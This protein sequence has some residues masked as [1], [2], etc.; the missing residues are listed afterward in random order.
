MRNKA[1]E[2]IFR[3]RFAFFLL[4]IALFSAG[5]ATA[6]RAQEE[7]LSPKDRIK[8]FERV[9]DLIND[10]YY[11]PNM[12]GVNWKAEREK[13]RPLVETA[14]NDGEFY[15]VLKRLTGELKDAHTRFLTPREA[16]E[17]R[18][19]QATTAGVLISKVE[20]RSVVERVLPE[21]DAA[22]AGIKAGM[23][24]RTIDGRPVAEKLA[25]IAK[26]LGPSSSERA[27]EI[28]LYRRLLSGEP[29]TRLKLGLRNEKGKDFEVELT[30]T[31]VSQESKVSAEKLPSGVGYIIVS[32]FKAPVSDK[33]KDA[34]ID[35]QDAPGLIIDLRY[36]GGGNIS[37]VLRMA[38]FFLNENRSFGK[39]L[40]RDGEEHQFLKDFT[41]GE[42]GGQIYAGPVVILVSQ[43]SASGS[44]L[45]SSGLQE[46]GRAQV[47]G[48]QTCGCLLGISRFHRMKGGGE[49]H[50]SD[51]G[52]LSAKGKIY[53]KVGVTP[54]RVVGLKIDDL[55]KDFDR[56]VAEAETVI[57]A[58]A[59]MK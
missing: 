25:E 20:G 46:F 33:F 6:V 24:V 38:G 12:N 45:F 19:R 3:R 40:R 50:I 58:S 22:R 37:E 59:E 17:F 29:G 14:R 39:F 18:T 54:D 41:A 43:Y 10:R 47:I 35:L 48:T 2:E 5:S 57:S 56:G 36:N 9:W 31:V 52:F 49:L 55:R 34:L 15:D 27:T 23:L 1:V 13:Y 30:R 11:D 32:S 53:E 16:R 28:L 8:V 44:E 51:I 26:D 42:K 4:V 7:E 21:S